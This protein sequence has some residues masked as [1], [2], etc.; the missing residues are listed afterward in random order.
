MNSFIK[1][2][3]NYYN[4]GKNVMMHRINIGRK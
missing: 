2:L 4:I 1:K 3:E